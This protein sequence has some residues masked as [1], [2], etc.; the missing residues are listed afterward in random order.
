MATARPDELEAYYPRLLARYSQHL[1]LKLR[2]GE[3]RL[4]R[5]HPVL[6]T[7]V[8]FILLIVKNLSGNSK[9]R[10][11]AIQDTT[12]VYGATTSTNSTQLRY[13]FLVFWLRLADV[14]M[15]ALKTLVKE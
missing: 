14:P 11:C 7:I 8:N 6:P 5:E 2:Y 4:A 15:G 3:A 12:R 9:P 10:T 1:S 13:S